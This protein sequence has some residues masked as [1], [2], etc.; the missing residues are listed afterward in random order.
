M[1][2]MFIIGYIKILKLLVYILNYKKNKK[3][4]LDN[5]NKKGILI[6]FE[7]FNNYLIFIPK[8]NKIINI[9]DIIIKKDFIY[10]KFFINNK[11]YNEVLNNLKL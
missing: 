10:K 6:G 9:K 2:K 8:E 1:K 5:K 7:S 3:N 4:K 11:N